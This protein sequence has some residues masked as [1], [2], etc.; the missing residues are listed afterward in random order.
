MNGPLKGRVVAE[1][2]ALTILALLLLIGWLQT[3]TPLGF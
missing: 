2:V 3:G 1:A